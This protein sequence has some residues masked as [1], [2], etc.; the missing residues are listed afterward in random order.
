[1]N[2]ALITPEYP[3]S[4]F[5]G[6][7]GGIG[8]FTKNL[9]EQLVVNDNEVTIFIHSQST[10]EVFLENN[11][12]IH[13][14][15]KNIV[16]GITWY[17]N[18]K[19]FN[20]YVNNIIIKK[21]IRIIEAPEWTGFTAFMKFKCPLVLRLHGSDTYFCDLENRKVK[22]KNF[23][24]ERKA[25]LGADRIVGVSNFVADKT[26]ELFKL[27]NKIETIH[28]TIDTNFFKPN[29]RHIKAKT[30][31]YFGTIV[32]KK[33]VLEIAKMFNK[34]VEQDNT[35]TLNLLG[36]DNIDFFTKTSTLDLFKTILSE[37]ALQNV[38]F[39]NAVPY[40][41]IIKHI[42]ETEVVLLPSF[43]EAFPMTWL[44]AMALEKKIITSD[45][46]WAKELMIDDET[47]YT[48]NPT[49]TSE[50]ASK[51]LTLIKDDKKSLDMAKEARNRIIN[52]FDIQ[53]S[54]IKN[55][56][57]YKSILK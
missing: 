38:R 15:K 14:V 34:I 18:R 13:L 8:T 31:L 27:K 19:Y 46:G 44:E 55:I 16:K 48:V 37:K 52:K 42:Q 29:H 57:M 25:L 39:L 5:N 22:K 32:R 7:V 20:K 50:F 4:S 49:N 53:Q 2:I 56:A 54:L 24:F 43:A 47:G 10:E 40:S 21:K 11:V 17:A 28:N 33:G 35:I 6:N 41:E 30:L 51:V 45:I 3:T 9:A 1:M 12:E 23:F 26:E 36:R